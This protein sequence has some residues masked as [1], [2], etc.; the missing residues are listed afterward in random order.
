MSEEIEVTEDGI[1]IRDL[2]IEDAELAAYVGTFED[3]ADGVRGLIDIAMKVQAHFT[4]DL[5]T[6]N[7]RA[8]ADDVIQRIEEAYEQLVEDL[9]EKAAL[10]VDPKDGPVIK[11]LNTAT[12]DNLK[13]LLN[14]ERDLSEVDLSPMARLRGLV[15][16]DIESLRKEVGD[17]LEE[18]KK[19][20][21]IG[22]SSRKTAADGVDFEGKVD[23]IVQN[24]ATIYG[25]TA[26]AIGAITEGGPSK[27]G[28]TEVELNYSDTNNIS[29]KIIWES[30][31]DKT[32]KGSATSRSPKVID[33]Q[34]KKEL[35]NAIE[36][37]KAKCAIMVLDNAGLDMDA[38]PEWRE[39]E[40]NKLLIVVD[41]ITPDENL[42][43][44]AY[45]WGRWKAKSSIGTNVVSVDFEGIKD[46]F[47]KI[48]MRLKDLS[49]IK[50]TNTTIVGLLTASSK[51]ITGIQRD[52]KG[53]M[54]ALAETI[55]IELAE[56]NDEIEE[57]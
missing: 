39:Y 56:I 14:P 15:N 48:R 12:G 42:I 8:A 13:K 53:M 32:F 36:T 4:T 6:Q 17:T 46:A 24:Y 3:P 22:A 31:T 28:D 45:L 19:K 10:L 49:N 40:G 27:K 51:D 26:I 44:L 54:E 34:V 21:G 52:T 5:E 7:I 41:P 37:R 35:N 18:I 11:A 47:D 23:L 20:L 2:E 55:N 9:Q 1:V 29:C 38:Q 25:D 43:R 16:D 33:D 50:R 30:K 57:N